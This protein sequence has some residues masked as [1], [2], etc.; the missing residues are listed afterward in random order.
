[1]PKYAAGTEVSSDRSRAEIERT[2]NRY[3]A[4]Q[5]MYGWDENRAIVGFVIHNRQVRF[6]LPLPDAN[7]REFTRTPTG[8]TRAANQVREA[9]EQAV[10]QKW[11]AL[12][13]VIKAK[14]EAVASEIVT[15]DAE[16]LAHLVLP[17]GQTVGDSV[18]PAVAEAYATGVTPQLLPNPQLALEQ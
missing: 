10:R 4:K 6:V 16:F 13:L 3:G 9:Y 7:D 8:R 1:M 5:F 2:L 15:F 11:R 14:L 17:N 12:A 18:M